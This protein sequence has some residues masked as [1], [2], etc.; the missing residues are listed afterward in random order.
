MQ[1]KKVIKRVFLTVTALIVCLLIICLGFWLIDGRSPQAFLVS[2]AL[3][4]TTMEDYERGKSDM[5]DKAPNENIRQS[6]TGAERIYEALKLIV[7]GYDLQG[8]TLRSSRI[9]N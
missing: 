4:Q 1:M 5:T 3:P 9:R 8:F 6:L 2:H 7:E